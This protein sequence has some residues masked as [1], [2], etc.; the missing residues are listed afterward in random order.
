VLSAALFLASVLATPDGKGVGS[1]LSS[2][3][4]R[5][6]VPGKGEPG[7]TDE[8]AA[9]FDERLT[10]LNA[11]PDRTAGTLVETLAELKMD[12][13]KLRFGSTHYGNATDWVE[14]RVSPGYVLS[15]AYTQGAAKETAFRGVRIIKVERVKDK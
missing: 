12:P 9:A 10:K 2:R 6:D 15:A 5:L 13:K 14:Y 1:L 3:W 11:D 7:Y 4:E 8:E